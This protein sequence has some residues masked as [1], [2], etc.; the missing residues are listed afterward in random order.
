[1][2]VNV[3][4]LSSVQ[5]RVEVTIPAKDV[6][7]ALDGIYKTIGRQVKIKGFRPG[8]VPRKI[9]ERHYGPQASA[10]AA[11]NL[12]GGSY[13][14]A[15]GEA[16][17]E[18]VARPD[19]DFSAPQAGEDFVYRVTLDVKPEF[20][21]EP[22][23]YKELK[24]KEPDFKVTD[25]DVDKHLESLRER[26][27]VTVPLEEERPAAIGDVVVIS[28][29]SSMDGE[30]VEGGEADNV[31]VEL[32]SGKAQAEIEAALVKAKPGD[33]VEASVSY[34]DDAPNPDFKGKDVV[35][36][37]VVKEL[38]N[39]VLPELD[40]D[41]AKSV[42]PEFESLQ[43]IKDRIKADMESTF[44]E[45]KD[46]ALKSQIMDALR[47]M[48][49]FEL[50]EGMVDAEAEGMVETVMQRL[51]QQGMDPEKAGLDLDKIRDD[52]RPQAE[53][54]VKAGIV[55]SKISD[56]EEVQVEEADR[57]EHFEKL[58]AQVGQPAKILREMYTKNNMMAD[59]AAQLLEEKTLRAI[60]AD[61]I[62]ELVDP[63]E[64]NENDKQNGESQE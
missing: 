35:F 2:K 32:G 53:K 10:E 8:K 57:D 49:E 56:M 4:E 5:R 42:S 3:E 18:P 41:F 52:F 60:K 19:F 37:L 13:P 61:A 9:M 58:S 1:M 48:A 43:A 21:L 63:A 20:E 6:D 24:L 15:L 62:I 28:Y 38:K 46:M 16:K 50:P 34:G 45:Q 12:I 30:P 17:V 7:N 23:K 27:A 55:L 33:I 64:L 44:Q 11:E 14:M 31:E 36:K 54:K 40:D 25:E 59:L 39:K 22:E 51:R 29:S 26:Q 47:E